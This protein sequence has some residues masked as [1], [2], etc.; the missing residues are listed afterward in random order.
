MIGALLLLLL[1]NVC[2]LQT[3]SHLPVTAV[4]IL[5]PD[6]LENNYTL[7]AD[8]SESRAAEKLQLF[9]EYLEQLDITEV[10]NITNTEVAAEGA[11]YRVYCNQCS[12]MYR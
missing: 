12:T 11:G 8:F 1:F 3:L 7:P 10:T 9:K 5:L 6:L 2:L 4:A